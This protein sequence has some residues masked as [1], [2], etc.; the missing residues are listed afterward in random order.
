LLASLVF[1]LTGLFPFVVGTVL[2]RVTGFEVRLEV[3]TAGALAVTALMLAAWGSRQTFSPTAGRWPTWGSWSPAGGERLAYGSLTVAALMG[4]LLQFYWHTGDLTIPLG[5]LGTLGGYF[6]FAPPL[7]WHRRGWGEAVGALCFGL[8]PVATGFYLQCGHLVT[9]VLLY[10]VP[11]TFA[12]FNLFLIHG[13][14]NPEEEAPPPGHSLAARLGP[15][16]GAL[17]FTLVN[18]LA[19]IGLVVC[20]FL[21]ASPLPFREGLWVVLLLAVINQELVKRK[22]YRQESRLKLLCRLTLALHLS[23]GLVFTL[24][25][26]QRL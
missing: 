20:L 9:E 24:M 19:I 3:F 15:T 23:M 21:P 16:A 1:L 2:A 8:L 17:I 12:G 4:L 22:A 5:G 14:P 10:G 7:N 6:Y 26:W 11:L 18:I 13:F 25:L